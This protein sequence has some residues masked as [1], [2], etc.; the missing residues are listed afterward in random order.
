MARI[1]LFGRDSKQL[2]TRQ[3]FLKRLYDSVPVSNVAELKAQVVEGNVDLLVLLETVSKDDA[4]TADAFL[5]EKCPTAKILSLTSRTEGSRTG[6]SDAAGAL[7][8][9]H[10]LLQQVAE[11]LQAA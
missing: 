6:L 9:T 1:L 2:E 5:Q 11:R 3:W 7:E 8:R 4:R 10:M